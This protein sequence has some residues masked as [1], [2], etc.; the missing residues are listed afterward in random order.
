MQALGLFFVSL[1]SGFCS[2]IVQWFTKRTAISLG[3]IAAIVTLTVAIFAAIN[4]I[5]DAIVVTAP[6]GLT[7]ACSWVLP[8][9]TFICVSA[10]MS[11][12]ILKW[13]WQW[14]VH[15]IEMYNRS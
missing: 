6:D 14:Q 7:Q 2:W 12:R 4:V 15:F 8:S 10:I 11:S 5:I 1:F 9:N 13:V 3:L